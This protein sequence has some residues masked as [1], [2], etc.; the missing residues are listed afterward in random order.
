VTANKL[1]LTIA[2]KDYDHVRDLS[3]GESP[4]EGIEARWLNMP[5]EEVFH[6]FHVHREFDVSEVSMARY[7]SAI[8]AGDAS[9]TA[10][11]V[12]PARVVRHSSFWVPAQSGIRDPG[13]LAGKRVGVP[14]WAQT[15]GVYMRGLMAHDYGV[16]LAGV[17]WVQ[18]GVN[19]AGRHEYSELA[20]PDGISITVE[21]TRSL[22][23]LMLTG[24]LDAILSA[25]PPLASQRGDGRIRRLFSDPEAAERDY[26]KRTGILP[27]M[28][29]IALRREIVDRDPWVPMSLFK[30]FTAAKDAS[31]ERM[32]DGATPRVPLPW[33]RYSAERAIAEAGGDPWPYGLE[34]NR[35]TLEAFL[36]F[37]YEQGVASRH[38]DPAD[39]F[40]AQ[41][42]EGFRI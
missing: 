29:T 15:A 10:I 31:V 11:P 41:I 20:L 4:I 16:D 21:S 3:S 37:A 13:E 24:E 39:L 32:L 35:V 12:F 30:A 28:H 9:I 26:V 19:E 33:I 25:R 23:E 8:A 34:A 42:D 5:I 36:L 6:R 2:S 22:N 40:A 1:K 38:L 18:G 17:Q 7:V 14:E 27:I